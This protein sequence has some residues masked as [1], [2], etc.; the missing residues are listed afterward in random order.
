MFD[1]DVFRTPEIVPDLSTYDRLVIAFSGGKDSIACF[2]HLLE[3]GVQREKI[4]LWHHDVDGREGN[5]FMDWPCTPA[6]CRAFAAAF[7]VQIYFS[8]R[9]GGFEREMLRN[10]APTGQTHFETPHGLHT[11]GG[12]SGKLGTRRCFRRSVLIYRF[13]IAAPT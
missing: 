1:L 8:W 12:K 4:E 6:Y 10:N 3:S 9:E 2:L 5:H 13:D 7:G 11:A